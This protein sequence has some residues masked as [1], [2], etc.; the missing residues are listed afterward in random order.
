MQF[1]WL[2]LPVLLIIQHGDLL[3]QKVDSR[4]AL[5]TEEFIRARGNLDNVLYRMQAKHRA[6]VAFLGGSITNMPGWRDQ[7]MKHLQ[8]SFPKTKFEFINAGIPSLGSVPHAFRL[9]RD[10][11]SKGR[12]DLLF[13]ESAVNDR[14]NATPEIQQRRAL[15]GIIRHAYASN[16]YLN[17][18][19][20]AFADE[21]KVN[22]Y[23]NGVVPAEIKLED[24]ISQ[25]YHLS[26]INLAEEVTRRI[27]NK[28]FSWQD[29][30]KSLHPSPFGMRIYFNSITTL[31]QKEFAGRHPSRLI[32]NALPPAMQKLNYAH[33]NY[34]DINGAKHKKGFVL[35]PLWQPRDSAKTRRGFVNRPMLVGEEPGASFDLEFKGVSAGIAVVSGPD[36]AKISYSL[37]GNNEVQLDTYNRYSKSLHLPQYFLLAED[38]PYKKHSLHIKILQERNNESRGTALRVVYFLVNK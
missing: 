4:H 38:L 28:E 25:Y 23:N 16:P 13:I 15:E 30:F 26:F 9:S 11:L 3:A 29:D 5:S 22:D 33:A 34:A 10:V 1:R 14:V 32:K 17:I 6:R 31:L 20:M 21:A 12:I 7:V 36:A 35:D 18:V 37:D 24:E 2:V 27:S 8:E 19:I